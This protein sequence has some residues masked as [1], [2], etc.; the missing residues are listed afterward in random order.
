DLQPSGPEHYGEPIF[1][2]ANTVIVPVKTAASPTFS[3]KAFNGA[4]GNLL[5]TIS[6]TY[7]EPP[8]NWL[9]PFQ[10]VYDAMSHRVYLA[11]PGGTV[12]YINN[13]DS[14]GATISGQL[15]FYGLANHQSNSAA[16]DGSVFIDTPLT[17]DNNGNVY[18]G[19]MVT[20]SNPSG[21]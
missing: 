3:L 7:Q 16:Y 18:F 2:A 15:A 17:I 21:L 5:W 12:Y 19:F 10:A 9:P 20:G 6:T 4:T 14:A 8:F 1:T 11:G 13:P